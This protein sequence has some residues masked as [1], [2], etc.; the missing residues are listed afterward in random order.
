MGGYTYTNVSHAVTRAL[1]PPMGPK[2]ASWQMQYHSG[3]VESEASRPAP[4]LSLGNDRKDQDCCARA[5]MH[6]ILAESQ[7]NAL[8]VRYSSDV[9][10]QFKALKALS[11]TLKGAAGPKLREWVILI[12]AMP[13]M[14]KQAADWDLTSAD[15]EAIDSR[16]KVLRKQLNILHDSALD[17]VEAHF[18]ET[19]LMESL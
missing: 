15:K 7:W 10:E 17:L 9:S 13:H 11:A 16:I 14:R 4:P 3:F 12:W 5:R 1:N 8:L 18:K 19:G 2:P 6:A